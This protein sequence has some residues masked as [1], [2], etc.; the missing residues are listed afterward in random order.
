LEALRRAYRRRFIPGGAMN[1]PCYSARGL[2]EM[3][4]EFMRDKDVKKR[5]D[6]DDI[7]WW[8]DTELTIRFLSYVRDYKL[9]KRSEE[10]YGEVDKLMKEAERKGM[11]G[12]RTKGDLFAPD[13]E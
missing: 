3:Y 9:N 11:F 5:L 6:K 8:Q 2:F 7:R 1:E 10:M 13:D 4:L 12:E